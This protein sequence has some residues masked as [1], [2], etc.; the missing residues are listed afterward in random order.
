[1]QHLHNDKQRHLVS[2][3]SHLLPS[4]DRRGERVLWPHF[5]SFRD[6]GEFFVPVFSMLSGANEQVEGRH[7]KTK[8]NHRI[9]E[10]SEKELG[11]VT[12]S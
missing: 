2:R 1:M 3:N 7:N 11:V 9:G 8:P 12:K 4:R 6:T 10:K 5:S